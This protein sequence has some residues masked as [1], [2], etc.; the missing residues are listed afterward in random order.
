MFFDD[1]F[2][3]DFEMYDFGALFDTRAL[4]L[5][6]PKSLAPPPSSE[7]V[8]PGLSA[9][10][11]HR[12]ETAL[13]GIFPMNDLTGLEQQVGSEVNRRDLAFL[14]GDSGHR[15]ESLL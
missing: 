3:N 13:N 15:V 12:Q 11:L 10:G 1:F 2:L 9:D 14:T 6:G 4:F 8:S 7:I 5:E